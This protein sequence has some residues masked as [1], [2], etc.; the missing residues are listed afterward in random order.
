M[1]ISFKQ[2]VIEGTGPF[3]IYTDTKDLWI[4]FSTWIGLEDDRPELWLNTGDSWIFINSFEIQ[5][6]MLWIHICFELQ[7]QTGMM[8]ISMNG[9]SPKR[10]ISKSLMKKPNTLNDNFVL[11]ISP[12]FLEDSRELMNIN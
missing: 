3:I 7:T 2:S 6:L 1:C 8:N 5:Y 11:G 4:S 12:D 10:I 9:N